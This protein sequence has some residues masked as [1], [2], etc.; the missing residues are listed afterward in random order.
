MVTF[1]EEFYTSWISHLD[2]DEL[3]QQF[4]SV[5]AMLH[6]PFLPE[7]LFDEILGSMIDIILLEA[8][9]RF[10]PL[11][12]SVAINEAYQYYFPKQN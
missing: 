5:D 9:E 1:D 4:I 7:S 8:M 6:T 2:N 12:G 3:I 10:I 11:S